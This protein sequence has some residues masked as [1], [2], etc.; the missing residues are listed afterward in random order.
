MAEARAAAI[1]V[2]GL[3]LQSKCTIAFTSAGIS[4]S[5]GIPDYRGTAG[6]DV[7]AQL[8]NA[9]TPAPTA[10]A[11]AAGSRRGSKR[12]RH[13]PVDTAAAAREADCG[14]DAEAIKASRSYAD[15]QP[16]PTHCALAEL[17]AAGRLQFT[18]TQNCDDLHGRAGTPRARL[19]ELHGNVFIE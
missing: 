13:E 3:V 15:L 10:D 9:A 19:V 14:E 2:A 12:R 4:C 5:A 17:D 1:V 18:I 7:V 8:G 11:S 6:V 16:T